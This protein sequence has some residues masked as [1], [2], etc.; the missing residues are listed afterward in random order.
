MSPKILITGAAG[1]GSLV[2]DFLAGDSTVVQKDQIIAAVRTKEQA[3]AL[4]NIG[5]NVLQVDLNDETA[6]IECVLQHEINL[7]IHN[8]TSI[9]PMPALYLIKALGKRRDVTKGETY[10]VHTS[11][12]SAFYESAGWN[13]GEV[14]DTDL[15][16]DLEKQATGAFPVRKTNMAVV[17]HAKALSVNS[18]IVAPPLVYGRGTGAWNKLSTQLPSCISAGISQKIVHRF[19]GSATAK[20]V[21]ISDLVAFYRL[22]LEGILQKQSL[23]SGELG[24]YFPLAHDLNWGEA[25][26]HVA[27]ALNARGLVTDSKARIWASD[28]VAAQA[29][30]IPLT[31][32]H[33][34]YNSSSKSI[35]ENKYKLGWEPKWNKERFLQS[36]DDE[37]QAVIEANGARSSLLDSVYNSVAR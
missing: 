33:I 6:V 7:V 30:H 18:F 16:F 24:Y 27:V 23:P 2:A 36:M 12:M 35:A 31:F 10:F 17:E 32:L 8:A 37:V 15:V 22:L 21:H 13:H 25:L 34:L 5:I 20:G 28:E 19:A 14:K 26:A 29:L 4:S 9:D 3:K 1:G 11:G